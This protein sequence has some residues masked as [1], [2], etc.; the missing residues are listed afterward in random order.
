MVSAA[1][2][3]ARN[4]PRYI[5]LQKVV[6]TSLQKR[7]ISVVSWDPRLPSIDAIQKKHYRAMT[8][9]DPY[10]KEVYPEAPLVAYRRPKNIREYLI[11]AKLPPKNRSYQSRQLNGMKKCKKSCLICPYILEGKHLK[12]NNFRWNIIS[13]VNCETFNAVYMLI[14]TK[15]RCI[16]KE[17]F[18]IV[19]TERTLKDRVCEHLGYINTKKTNQPAG[20]HFNLPGHSK[21]DMKVTILEKQYK[22]DPEYRKERESFLIR[23]FNTF[24][25]GM[26]KKP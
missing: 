4:I 10:L 23:K 25:R 26:N 19:E 8:S 13:N 17:Q 9:I 12:H 6:K 1:I 15:E 22:S 3:K 11:R 14:C 21:Q 20:Y 16:G 18:Y 7:P 5:A 2:S 24:R